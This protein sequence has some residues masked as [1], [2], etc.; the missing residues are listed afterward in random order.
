MALA[1]SA[2]HHA[3]LLAQLDDL[4]NEFNALILS[5]V[6]GV[7]LRVLQLALEAVPQ[8]GVRRVT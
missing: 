7:E 8:V 5:S 4:E 2:L 3:A 1:R 6:G